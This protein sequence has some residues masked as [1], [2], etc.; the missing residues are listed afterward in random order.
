MTDTEERV[1]DSDDA[2]MR[3]LVCFDCDSVDPLPLYD[4]P[5]E[6]DEYLTARIGNH[7]TPGGTPHRGRLFTVSEKSWNNPSYRAEILKEIDK[8]RGGGDTGLGTRFYDVR[9]TFQEDA[10]TCWRV[11]H[12]RTENCEDYKS[13]KMRLVPDTKEERKDLGMETRARHIPGGTYLCMFCPYASIVMERQ[14]KAQ[15]FY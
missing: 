12:N 8:A 10:M 1:V 9:S 11:K 2:R 3:I 4:G 5:P 13:D 14:R 15:G 6:H 7:R